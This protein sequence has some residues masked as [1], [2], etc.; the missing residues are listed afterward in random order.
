PQIETEAEVVR[1]V[2]DL[3]QPLASLSVSKKALKEWR[4]R[5]WESARVESARRAE[6]DEDDAPV[7]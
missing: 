4:G 2:R 5:V 3:Q 7:N 1:L 6:E